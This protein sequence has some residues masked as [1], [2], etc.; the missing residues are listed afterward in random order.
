MYVSVLTTA[1]RSIWGSKCTQTVWAASRRVSESE[2]GGMKCLVIYL[3]NIVIRRLSRFFLRFPQ[4]LMREMQ[5]NLQE[6]VESCAMCHFTGVSG[7]NVIHPRL[8]APLAYSASTSPFISVTWAI[9][10]SGA[11]LDLI[12]QEPTIS[13]IN[14]VHTDQRHLCASSDRIASS[15]GRAR[16]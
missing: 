1:G 14:D 16:K 2:R 11:R 7:C 8:T 6:N 13:T 4:P 10:Y 15:R 5:Y 9:V 3:V 12:P